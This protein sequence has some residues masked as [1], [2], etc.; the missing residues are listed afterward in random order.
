MASVESVLQQASH[1]IGVP[2][3]PSWVHL[4]E[5]NGFSTVQSLEEISQSDWID[6]SLPLRL[7]K[8]LCADGHCSP[9]KKKPAKESV[10][11]KP[12]PTG[13]LVSQAD[14]LFDEFDSD[15]SG[16]MDSFELRYCLER[17]NIRIDHDNSLLLLQRVDKN[18]DGKIQ[19]DEFLD[20]LALVQDIKQTFDEA[21]TDGSQSLNAKELEGLFFRMKIDLPSPVVREFIRIFDEDNSGNIDYQ[22]FF[23]LVLYIRE[24]QYQY[25]QACKDRPKEIT[26]TVLGHQRSQHK[27]VKAFIKSTPKPSF[28]DIVKLILEVEFS[29]RRKKA[30]KIT[31]V[32]QDP[33]KEPP[34]TIPKKVPE[35][36]KK[37]SQELKSQ[38]PPP[39]IS[40]EKYE[41]PDFPPSEKFL[42]EA[43]HSKV[44]AW[45]R[46]HE[47]SS[48]PQIFISGV[49][50][51][52]VVQGALGDCWFVSALSVIA[53]SGTDFIADCFLE[54]NIEAG[55]YR[56][57]FFK[58]GVWK[59]VEIDDRLPCGMSGKPLFGKC[60]SPDEFWV[61]LIEKAYA[62]LHGGYQELEGGSISDGLRD[63]TGEAVQTFH[64][65]DANS[66]FAN[67]DHLLWK[68]LV[69]NIKESFL[70]GCAFSSPVA[71]AEEATPQGLLLNHA[72]GIIDCQEVKGHK[73]VR[74]RNPWGEHEWMGR[75]SDGSAEWTP[76]IKA[77]FNYE[78]GDDGTFFMAF[79]DF[80]Q[81]FNRIQV[82]L[83][84][85][86][87]VG[88]VWNKTVLNSE[89]KGQS[90]GGCLNH[91][92]WSKNPQF[93]L[94]VEQDSTVFISLSQPDLRVKGRKD[95]T[96]PA[97]GLFVFMVPD[98]RYKA[99]ACASSQIVVQS[100][101]VTSRD[102]SA[103][104]QAEAGKKYVVIPC[105]FQPGAE[106]PFSIAFYT[107]KVATIQPIEQEMKENSISGKWDEDH[108]GGCTNHP[109]W[110]DN[111]QYL[112]TVSHDVKAIL[113]LEQKIEG[114]A[115]PLTIGLYV[116][117]SSK[118][119]PVLNPK[120]LAAKPRFSNV[121]KASV[122]MDL[123]AGKN[124]IL[125]PSTFEPNKFSEFKVSVFL[126]DDSGAIQANLTQTKSWTGRDH[127]ESKWTKES[128]G[129]MNN[130]TWKE[131][132]K[133]LIHYKGTQS[134][135][136]SEM[137]VL[138]TAPAGDVAIGGHLFKSDASGNL[139]ELQGN[140]DFVKG[141]ST[142]GS[143]GLPPSDAYFVLY[144]C[145]FEAQQRANFLIDV[146]STAPVS[147]KSL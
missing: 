128:G 5:Q 21:D 30:P 72:Y 44:L 112:L 27:S 77:H 4:L 146:F 39:K 61:P 7:Y 48:D 126:V 1:K 8:R 25:D 41:D 100:T 42:P 116:F 135:G 111:P 15:R 79:E 113:T 35:S 47:L 125:M 86:D 52:D 130:K 139:K 58:D 64:L 3:E 133:F 66:P 60:K 99:L 131:N 137:H 81:Q 102:V 23:N 105:Y 136:Q 10:S 108:S 109:T 20:M 36:K 32:R 2:Y 101:F 141:Q 119:Y 132:P 121:P 9:S 104:F 29:G 120:E 93:S 124:Y 71:K 65:E 114:D 67:D 80:I 53:T 83:L 92:T 51:G 73:L 78:F 28:E 19:R 97:L 13:D 122:E 123:Q 68:T 62:K 144:P 57:K 17:L 18:N 75:W 134:D 94:E 140:I 12:K 43:A 59:I 82:L 11:S 38:A 127:K 34:P 129:C 106:N 45:K 142:F 55:F 89:W 70:M 54:K 69:R 14:K 90:A 6:L 117:N 95:E 50:E 46:L 49:E 91:P 56:I 88:E 84:M 40:S 96:Y 98:T 26:K 63:L 22:E 31:T 103:E 110:R 76:E 24:L 37:E 118:G 143:F 138:I 16:E 85:T 87:D 33:R 107:Q 115:D 145:T 74:V 147:V